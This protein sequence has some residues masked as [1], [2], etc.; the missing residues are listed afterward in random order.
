[1]SQKNA[2]EDASKEM[3]VK[4][5][6]AFRAAHRNNSKWLFYE[7]VE[8]VPQKKANRKLDTF[9]NVIYRPYDLP[10]HGA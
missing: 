7:G 1:V 5:A 9:K 3:A 2:G 6:S 10:G 8:I 4:S